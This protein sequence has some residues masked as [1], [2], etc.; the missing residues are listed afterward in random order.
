[1]SEEHVDTERAFVE[2]PSGR[3]IAV[4]ARGARAELRLP[5]EPY[6]IAKFD[7]NIPSEARAALAAAG[8]REVGYLPYDALLLEK[9][10]ALAQG[11]NVAA[12]VIAHLA[13]WIPYRP[14]DRVSND[15][16]HDPCDA[17]SRSRRSAGG[18]GGARR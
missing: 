4:E 8:F 12:P 16:R 1:M 17:G 2:T 5:A 3:R 7:G 6:V 9:P 13:A 15:L 14:E 10:S 18:G 11:A